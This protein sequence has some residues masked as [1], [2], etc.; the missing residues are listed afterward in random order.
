MEALSKK[1]GVVK[2]DDMK[3]N[4][5]NSFLSFSLCRSTSVFPPDLTSVLGVT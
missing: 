3:E 5:A 1:H 4:I 2:E